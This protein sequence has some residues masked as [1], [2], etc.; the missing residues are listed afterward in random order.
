MGTFSS[1]WDGLNLILRIY[2]VIA[3]PFTVI[4]LLQLLLSFFGGGDHPDDTPDADVSSDHGINFQFIT[5]KNMVGFFTIFAWTGI[6]C[7][8]AGLS[9]GITLL[10]SSL[11]GIGMMILMAGIYYL[12]SRAGADGTLKMDR[13][14]GLEGEVY[15]TIPSSRTSIGKVQILVMGSLR[16]LDAM[17]DAEK[18]I[19]TGRII[20]VSDI[21]NKSIL[22]VHEKIVTP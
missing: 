17:T 21:I 19:P 11:A 22:L 5:F 6:A 3:V 4:F 10:I 20:S 16:T 9:N 13:A 18:D 14:I 15:L 7:L 8:D 1:W 12:L 2:W